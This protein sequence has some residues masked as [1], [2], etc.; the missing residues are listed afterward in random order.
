MAG[1]P[2][3]W[4]FGAVAAA[5][6]PDNREPGVPATFPGPCAVVAAR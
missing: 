5:K 3:P 2:E 1:K 4:Y 6:L